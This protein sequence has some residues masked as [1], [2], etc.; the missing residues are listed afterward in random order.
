MKAGSVKLAVMFVKNAVAHAQFHP[1]RMGKSDLC[2][3]EFL[4]AGLNA[5]EP[6]QQNAAHTHDSQDKLYYVLQGSGLVRIGEEAATLHA[7]DAA[8]APAGVV[9]S[10]LNSGAEKLI[11]MAVMAPP[12]RA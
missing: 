2:R 6:G 1:E 4:F 7:G 9:H 5:F 3:G 8:L 12:P 10:I 11:V